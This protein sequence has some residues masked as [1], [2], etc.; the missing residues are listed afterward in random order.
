MTTDYTDDA[1]IADWARR[2]VEWAIAR[3]DM[4]GYPEDNTWRPQSPVT[5]E[6]LATIRW[7]AAGMP[8]PAEPPPTEDPKPDP[9]EDPP[10]PE[11]NPAE[12]AIWDLLA[13][14]VSP[15]ADSGAELP[16]GMDELVALKERRGFT[17]PTEVG[18]SLSNGAY[19]VPDG[20]T[21]D[22]AD[23][24][25]RALA[26]GKRAVIGSN[27]RINGLWMAQV[28]A[29]SNHVIA[30]GVGSK[31]S[32]LSN[33]WVSGGRGNAAI[34]A[35]KGRGVGFVL[36]RF[37]VDRFEGDG[38][39]HFDGGWITD[40]VVICDGPVT[41]KHYDGTQ[42]TGKV[43]TLTARMVY[44]ML[45]PDQITSAFF[46]QR[47]KNDGN[48]DSSGQVIDVH[49]Y[50]PDCYYPVRLHGPDM[51]A[52][53]VVGFGPVGPKLATGAL[54]LHED[55]AGIDWETVWPQPGVDKARRYKG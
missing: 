16:R 4:T 14:P 3:G 1:D 51:L 32:H 20:F 17:M 9:P 15:P 31:D 53:R 37:V 33:V 5:R 27:V 46:A 49:V 18:L 23:H 39:K 35:S 34:G 38:T 54:V 43:A 40:G 22:L 29:G 12:G 47:N 48:K 52:A 44:V 42:S 13:V 7:R 24:D 11:P 6:M 55:Q 50:A 25:G 36:E 30:A 26:L 28:D 41:G 45:P 10:P 21:F 8:T 19:V 2:G